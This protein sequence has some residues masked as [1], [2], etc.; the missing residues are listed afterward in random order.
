MKTERDVQLNGAQKNSFYKDS[1]L[2]TT[3]SFFS[4]LS[5]LFFKKT[6]GTKKFIYDECIFCEKSIIYMHCIYIIYIYNIDILLFFEE[7][8]YASD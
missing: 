6:I 3:H 5:D 2:S 1:L 7:E 8:R 4:S